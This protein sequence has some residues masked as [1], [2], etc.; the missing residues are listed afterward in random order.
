MSDKIDAFG[1]QSAAART[2]NHAQRPFSHAEIELLFN[3]LGLVSEA[4]ECSDYIKK[5]IWHGHGVDKA[6]LA[7]ELGDICWYVAAV[8][9]LTGLELQD[10]LT[11]NI[12]KLRL[13]YPNGFSPEDS[14]ARVDV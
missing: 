3:A 14:L 10:V 6:K 7:D 5:A 1:Y 11:A 2:L 8:C 13:R 12:A 4:G 9:T